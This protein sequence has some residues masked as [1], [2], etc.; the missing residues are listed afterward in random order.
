MIPRRLPC[1]WISRFC[2]ADAPGA[3]GFGFK[4]QDI[5]TRTVDVAGPETDARWPHVTV[6]GPEAVPPEGEQGGMD[7]RVPIICSGRWR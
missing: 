1:E 7:A 3:Q 4:L 5:V 2:V 6:V